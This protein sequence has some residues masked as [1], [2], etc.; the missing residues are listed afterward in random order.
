MLTEENV[1]V[2]LLRHLE[3]EPQKKEPMEPQVFFFLF[4]HLVWEVDALLSLNPY[5]LERI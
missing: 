3:Q 5:H 1:R 4:P 2:P